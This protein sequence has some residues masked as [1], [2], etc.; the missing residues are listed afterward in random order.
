MK[1]YLSRGKYTA[2]GWRELVATPQDIGEAMRE[3]IES[4][5]SISSS[6]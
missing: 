4:G 1:T 5:R 3:S 6:L 2:S